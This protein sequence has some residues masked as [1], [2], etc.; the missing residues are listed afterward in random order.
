VNWSHSPHSK[1][2]WALISDYFC[3]PFALIPFFK[4]E[5]HLSFVKPEAI[6]TMES[7]GLPDVGVSPIAISEPFPL[8]SQEAVDII[9][10]EILADEFQKKDSFTNDLAPKALRGYAAKGVS[11]FLFRNRI[12]HLTACQVFVG[13]MNR[14][15]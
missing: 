10:S 2:G 15:W 5:T 9:R 6:C 11:A 7:I 12:D 3:D 4:P 1:K 8:F 14:P 13:S